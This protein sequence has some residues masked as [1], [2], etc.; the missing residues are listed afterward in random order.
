ML[1]F[2]AWATCALSRRKKDTAGL[3]K[4]RIPRRPWDEHDCEAN[5]GQRLCKNKNK[6]KHK[7]FAAEWLENDRNL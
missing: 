2:R 6:N 1:I 3:S 5:A 7:E 4:F